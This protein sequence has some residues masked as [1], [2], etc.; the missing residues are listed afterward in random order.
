MDDE[1]HYR[2][3]KHLQANPYATQRELAKVLGISLGRTNYCL[4]ALADRGWIKVQ[5]FRRSNNK[6]A[7]AYLL[8]PGGIQAK[9]QV[10]R[11]L[12]ERK[13]AEYSRLR[14]V[15][16]ELAAEDEQQADRGSPDKTP[17]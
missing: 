3:L 9:A 17:V 7:Y 5:N 11:K 10:V 8:T 6:L 13:R 1:L 2:A 15:I 14:R 16:D 12:L 4:R